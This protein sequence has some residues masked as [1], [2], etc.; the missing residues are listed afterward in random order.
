MRRLLILSALPL[1]LYGQYTLYACIT[2]TKDYVV[3][4]QLTPSG[5]FI[6]SANDKWQHAGFNHPFLFSLDYDRIKA[7]LGRMAR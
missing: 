7:V 5:L 6:K 2:S 3:G 4:A 1:H